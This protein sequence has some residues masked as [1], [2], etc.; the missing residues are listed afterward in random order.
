MIDKDEI[1]SK[2][3]EAMIQD[4]Q[5]VLDGTIKQIGLLY[6]RPNDIIVYIESIG[7]KNNDDFETNGWQWDYWLTLTIDNKKYSISGDGYYGDTVYFSLD[8]D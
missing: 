8:D 7:G 5:S 4:I 2:V 1:K 3:K 6:V